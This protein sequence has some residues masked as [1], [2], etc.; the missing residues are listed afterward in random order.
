MIFSS[1]SQ[2]YYTN[3]SI[4]LNVRNTF[5]D[6]KVLIIFCISFF[7]KGLH[8]QLGFCQGNSGDPIFSENFG[9]GTQDSQLPPGTTTYTYANN[10]NPN[11]GLY[12]VSSNSNYFDWFDIND[13]TPND[14]NGRM[15]IINSDFSAGEF[16]RTTINGLC[17]NTT[18]EFSS[19]L[20]NLSPAGG[21]C[22]AGVI[23]INVRFEIWD[24]TDTNLL[25]SGTTGNITSTTAPD[26]NQYALVFQS[27]PAQTSVI[28]KMLNNGSGGCGNDLAID[29]IVFKSCGDS[30]AVEDSNNNDNAS[31]CSSIS[32]YSDTITAI[33]DNAVFNSHFYQWQVSTD[34]ITWVDLVGETNASI[35][36]TG[37]TTTSFY[38]AKVAEFAANLNNADC[39]TFSDIFQIIITQ[40]PAQPVIECWQIATFNDVSCSW[41]VTGTQPIQPAIECWQTTTFNN[42]T[43]IW[44]VTGTQPAQPAIECW[45]M[46]NFNNTS[47]IWEVTGTQPAQP[48]IECWQ[49]ATFNNITCVW[50]VNGTQPVA[51]TNLECWQTTTFNNGTCAWVLVGTQPVQPAIEC[52]QTTTFNNA[53]CIWDITGTQPA[54]PTGLECWEIA[55]F[56]NTTCTWE[57]SGTQPLTPNN[58]ECWQSTTFSIV[59]CSWLITGIQPPAPNNLECW[60]ISTFNNATC[61]WEISGTQSLEPTNLECWETA[62]FSE[63]SCIWEITGTQPLDFRDEF[64]SLCENETLL[65]QATSSIIN[66]SYDWDSGEMTSSITIDSA[67]SYEVEIT[68]GCFTEIITFIITAIE[69]PII[70]S[71]VS[72]GSTIII[73][74]LND[75]DYLYSLDG[76][77]FQT[78]NIFSN[79]QSGLYTIYVKSNECDLVVI[80]EHLHFFIPKFMTPNGD[81]DNDFF[82]LNI[83]EFFISTEV[84]IFDRYGK[85]LFSAINRNVNWDGTFN[86]SRLPTSDYWYVIKIDGQEFKGHFT[87]KN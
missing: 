2:N 54:M 69:N 3:L 84:Y 50:D 14:T 67:G 48:A 41:S 36:V 43:C 18:Y 45:E 55:I 38:R 11:D 62:T 33:P 37:V 60:E 64:L 87:L 53:T 58:L 31:L 78:S 20:I 51:P 52:W 74:L 24:N 72:E 15:L 9:T 30:I 65:L 59:S 82:S 56:N 76:I 70:E 17:E 40:A 19:W 86:N 61:G 75:G 8:A 63:V 81:G 28:L 1:K 79:R 44:E 34:G 6:H 16:Y 22:G 23:P 57:V 29:D 68:D 71:V 83:L 66:P 46:A 39:I 73:N 47:C 10:Q 7:S 13:H 4:Y 5:L 32:P 27:L 80:Q 42:T 35:T 85:L 25:A 21:F 77:D 26:W 49:T 12:T